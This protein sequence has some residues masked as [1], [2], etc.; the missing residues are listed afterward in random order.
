MQQD[1][2][3]ADLLRNLVS[4]D[5]HRRGD[6]EPGV[7]EKRR[8]DE[9]AVD[10]VVKPV[11]NDDHHAGASG[12][13]ACAVRVGPGPAPVIVPVTPDR[14]FLQKEEREEPGE[15]QR[16]EGFDAV[17]L[18][19]R[20]GQQLE[21]CGR[22]HDADRIAHHA[23]HPGRQRSDRDRGRAEDAYDSAG[24]SGG[25]DPDEFRVDDRA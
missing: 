9:D 15:C 3:V 21:E 22:E 23:R 8:G 5:R 18:R 20:L 16:E 25:D 6:A 1:H 4:D 17:R 19:K 13:V 7:R 10:E 14:H 12:A 2:E 24:E 11:A